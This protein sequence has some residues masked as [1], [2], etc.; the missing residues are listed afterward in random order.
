MYLEHQ[1]EIERYAKRSPEQMYNTLE[2][3][4]ATANRHFSSVPHV[5]AT[6]RGYSATQLTS[7]AF[8]YEGRHMVYRSILDRQ[9]DE[10]DLLR[11]L[12]T[13]PYL[14]V[15]KAG[16]A[17]QCIT[18]QV[19]CIDVW[20]RNA[21]GIAPSILRTPSP[22]ARPATITKNLTLYCAACKVIGGSARM[23]DRW[24]QY[25]ADAYTPS[26]VYYPWRTAD[27][28]S[29]FHVSTCCR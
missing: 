17:A 28:V 2:F 7:L 6:K 3:V 21:H 12:V 20:N 8:L 14:G 1:P 26:G 11:Y 16:F 27:E 24:C 25:L 5:L 19:G 4:I 18:G 9:H 29:A 10:V 13:L 15:V 23:W 22:T